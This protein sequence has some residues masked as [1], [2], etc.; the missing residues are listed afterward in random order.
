MAL[1]QFNWLRRVV[2][3]NTRPIQYNK[4]IYWKEK[5]SIVY[6]LVAWNAFG[7]VCYMIYTGKKDWA[8]FHG[9]KSEEDLKLSPGKNKYLKILFLVVSISTNNC[10]L[11]GTYVYSPGILNL[12]Y[13]ATPF[14]TGY[15]NCLKHPSKR[16][17]QSSRQ[18][19]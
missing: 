2:R 6:M 14:F 15:I 4:A 5:L 3:R 9:I 18:L 10:N 11:D 7:F 17:Y 19:F 12:F 1:F 8:Q 16:T 13:T